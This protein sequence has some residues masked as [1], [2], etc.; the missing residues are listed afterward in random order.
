MGFPRDVALAAYFQ[1]NGDLAA[2]L[3]V[4]TGA[5]QPQ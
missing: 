3:D 5:A 2:A 1:V 4:L